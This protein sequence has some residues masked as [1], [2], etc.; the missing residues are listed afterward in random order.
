MK[1]DTILKMKIKILTTEDADIN[2]E[3]EAWFD[4]NPCMPEIDLCWWERTVQIRDVPK[5]RQCFHVGPL[6]EEHGSSTSEDD[7]SEIDSAIQAAK[8]EAGMNV[9]EEMLCSGNE[10]HSK[11]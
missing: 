9:F 1:K 11:L 6:P 10:K 5:R 2:P 3:G 4:A 8:T 7:S